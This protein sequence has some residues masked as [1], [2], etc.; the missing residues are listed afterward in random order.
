MI[1]YVLDAS[2]GAKWISPGGT[3]PLAAQAEA[4]L[5]RYI[6]G[7]IQ[8]VVPD[9]FWSEIAS[10]LWKAVRYNKISVGTAEDGLREMISHNLPTVSSRK[11][12]ADALQIAVRFDRTPYDSIYVALAEAFQTNL[13]TADERLANA[14]AAHL[15]V[16]WLGSL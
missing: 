10:F 12:L 4:L 6:R 1:W 11:V 15:P 7:Q 2:V 13:I 16:K 14:L 5:R 9:L 8:L 3:E